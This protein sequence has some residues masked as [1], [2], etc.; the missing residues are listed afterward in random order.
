MEYLTIGELAK[1]AGVATSALRFYESRGIVST[2]TAEPAQVPAG[3]AETCR[4]DPGRPGGRP[5]V[6]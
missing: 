5:V 4:I 3:N 6:G 2:R 1:R